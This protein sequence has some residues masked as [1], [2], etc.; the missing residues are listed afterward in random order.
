MLSSLWKDADD[1]MPQRHNVQG[2]SINPTKQDIRWSIW[3][4][5]QQKA[6]ELTK[7][8]VP[9]PTEL[10]PVASASKATDFSAR[11][12][13][14]SDNDTKARCPYWPFTTQS[15][16]LLTRLA[17]GVCGPVLPCSSKAA[18]LLRPVHVTSVLGAQRYITY[19]DLQDGPSSLVEWLVNVVYTCNNA[20]CL[21]MFGMNCCESGS[22][23]TPL[24]KSTY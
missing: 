24:S 10:K 9:V 1:F 14:A 15:R 8:T 19:L 17:S 6:K 20:V 21:V 3:S 4:H 23:K 13:S 2:L 18:R 12:P 5:C 22:S 16:V 7:A 11:N